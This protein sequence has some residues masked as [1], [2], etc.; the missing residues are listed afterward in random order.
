MAHR[1]SLAVLGLAALLV[2]CGTTDATD[3]LIPD[4]FGRVRFVSLITDTTRG[5]VNAIL[6]S[7]PFGV[8]LTYGG[9]TPSS[10]PAPATAIYSPIL[11]GSRSL[12][13]KRTA[14]TSVTVATFPLTIATGADYTVYATGGSGASAITSFITTDTNS[15]PASG[16]VR[17][18]VVHLAP[19]AGNVDVFVTAVG[20]NLALATPTLANV[21]L[22]A[23]AYLSVPAG[24]YQ[25]RVVPAGTAP[26][27]RA[28]N[29]AIN[30]PSVAL[31]ANG[32][33]TIIAADNN[34]GGAPFRFIALVDR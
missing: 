27:D 16:A 18:R 29:V 31:P 11:T 33:R 25:V 28:T 23:S 14:D 15:V 26:A 13:L 21:P 8:N 17:V 4:A 22:R 5:R 30:L 12:V 10:L 34:T 3:P 2:G 19:S 32:A 1:S 6:E 20:A 9:T 7:V 24:T